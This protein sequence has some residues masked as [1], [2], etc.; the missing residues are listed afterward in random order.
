[1][2]FIR[3]ND[4]QRFLTYTLSGGGLTYFDST[5]TLQTAADA[6]WPLDHDPVTLAPRGNPVWSQRTNQL[7]NSLSPANQTTGSL[8][9]GTYTLSLVGSGSVTVAAGTATITNGGA[10]TQAAPRPFVVTGAG[11]VTVTITG[12]VTAFQIE[13]GAFATPIIPTAGATATR[14]APSITAALGSWFNATQ[15]T[16]V[17]SGLKPNTAIG[18]LV[19]IDNGLFNESYYITLGSGPGNVVGQVYDGGVAQAVMNAGAW[20]QNA[21]IN[22]ALAYAV[23]DFATVRNGSTPA[24]DASGTLPTPTTLRIGQDFNSAN[25]FLNGWMRS[26]AY[27]PTRLPNTTLQALTA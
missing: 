21:N 6:L 23:N 8:A 24:T 13:L 9:T 16:I 15:G 2:D 3:G 11:T 18:G 12:T 1:M 7:L 25:N 20:V 17:A 4:W 27:Y 22:A 5:G 19:S 14:N 10:A 26:F